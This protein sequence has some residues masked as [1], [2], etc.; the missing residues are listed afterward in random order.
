MTVLALVL[1]AVF[2]AID[3]VTKILATQYLAPNGSYNVL[4]GV[5]EFRYL[6]N[7][8]MA[9]S[10]LEGKQIFLIIVTSIFLLVL[11]Y[12]LFLKRPSNKWLYIAEILILSGGIGNLIDRVLRGY[13]VD[14]INPTFMRFA[15]FNVA[16][17]YV[18]VGAII[19][20]ITL[21]V[22]EIQESKAKKLSPAKGA[23]DAKLD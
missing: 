16:D 4:P 8:G 21:I 19:L 3:R 5:L 17:I 12:F 23:D 1:C 20:I 22:M 10:M 7:D 13:V 2:I 6:E 11:A 15:N 18:S 9:F 14:F